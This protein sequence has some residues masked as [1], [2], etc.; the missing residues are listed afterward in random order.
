[1]AEYL[2]AIAADPLQRRAASGAE[3][4]LDHQ[5]RIAEFLRWL[6]Q[7]PHA[8]VVLVAHEETLR[9]CMA[10]AEGWP[11]A[12]VVGKAFDNGEVYAFELPGPRA[13]EG[14]ARNEV[15]GSRFD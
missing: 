3:T 9:V 5:A 4:L 2:A 8:A 12:A 7:Q 10:T 1:V 6:V 11:L 14:G 13:D 15:R